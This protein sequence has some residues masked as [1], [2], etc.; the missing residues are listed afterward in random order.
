MPEAYTNPPVRIHRVTTRR[1]NLQALQCPL[2]PELLVAE[3]AG[4]LPPDVALAVREHIA[5]CETCGARSRTLRTPY[6]LLASLGTEPVAYVPDLRDSVRAHLRHNRFTKSMLRVASGLTRGGAIGVSSIIGLVAVAAFLLAGILYSVNAHGVS[7]SAN[8]LSNVPPAGQSGML[9]AETNKLVTVHDANGHAWQV[10]EV[11]AVDERTGSVVQSLPSSSDSLQNASA[12][13]LPVALRVSPDGRTVYEVTAPNA[14]HQQALVAFDANTGAV[15]YVATLTYT[16]GT[17]LAGDNLAE[18]L[19]VAPNGT[20]VYIGLNDTQPTRYGTTRILVIDA[21][22]GAVERQLYPGSDPMIPMPPPPGSLP[23][24]A[25]PSSVPKLNASTYTAT[26]GAHGDIAVSPDGK[27]IFDVLILSNTNGPQYAVV[28]RINVLTGSLKQELAI[29]G[30]FTSSRLVANSPSALAYSQAQ[31][32]AV[33]Q[34]QATATAQAGAH[35]LATPTTVVPV[36]PALATPQLYLVKGSPEAQC[37]VLDP[38]ATGPTLTGTIS[39][40]GPAAPP[41]TTFT[42][43]L[44]VSPSADGTHLYVT[45]NASAQQGQVTG[46]DL[47]DLDVQAMGVLSHRVESDSAD[48]VQANALPSGAAFILRGGNVLVIN[49]DLSGTPANWMSLNSGQVIG[50]VG[51]TS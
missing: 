30:D 43:T 27:W 19:A 26:V 5:V 48:A 17:P 7:R 23:A 51:A 44:S 6:Q 1:R 49:S 14:A 3:F 9:L 40:G 33:A 13:Q 21:S 36:T 46:H 11:I 34:V 10:A 39:L 20:M 38:S 42:G 41:G 18:S 16:T 2:E 12:N 50:F 29:A 8:T 28:R 37:F 24:S 47:W 25:F 4:E 31:A 22:S 35:P 15:H 45:Q 32:T